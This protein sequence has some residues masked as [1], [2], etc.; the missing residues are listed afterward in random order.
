MTRADIV[1]QLEALSVG[2]IAIKATGGFKFMRFLRLSQ[3][4]VARF[5]DETE[6]NLRSTVLRCAVA[7]DFIKTAGMAEEYRVVL[8]SL[9]APMAGR[10]G[11][12]V[13]GPP[14]EAADGKGGDG[15]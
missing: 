5:A 10:S 7:E 1:M 8:A 3:T 11:L 6:R 12:A 13:H 15:R 14:V 2:I 9:G 4:D